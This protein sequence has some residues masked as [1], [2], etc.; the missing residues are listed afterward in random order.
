VDEFLAIGL[1]GQKLTGLS[2]AIIISM[3]TGTALVSARGGSIRHIGGTGMGGGTLLGLSQLTLNVRDFD[4]VV[5]LARDGDLS[6][7]DLTVGDISKKGVSM[8]PADSTASNFGKINE[9]ATKA[10]IAL[11]IVNVVFQSIGMLA[12]FACRADGLSDVIL[13]GNLTLIPQARQIFDIM[14]RIFGV[15]FIIPDHAEYSTAIGAAFAAV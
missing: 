1:G 10:D 7:I 8:L 13:T 6:K 5:A 11:G 4:H 14:S 15:N 12:V 3:G 2:E 9:L